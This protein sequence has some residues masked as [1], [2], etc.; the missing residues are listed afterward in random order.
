MKANVEKRIGMAV[1]G[2]F[3][4][5]NGLPVQAGYV[6]KPPVYIDNYISGETTARGS[7]VAARYSSDSQPYIGC[8]LLKVANGGPGVK[9]VAQDY[10]G[11][12]LFCTGYDSK[13]AEPVKAITDSSYIEFTSANT[14]GNCLGLRVDNGSQYLR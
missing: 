11:K 8:Y 6:S 14:N 9:C 1:L 2:L 4:G 7:M 5:L 13:W 3:V 10:S 12:Y